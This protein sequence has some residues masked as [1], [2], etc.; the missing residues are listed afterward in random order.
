MRK[1]KSLSILLVVCLLIGCLPLGAAADSDS[2]DTSD[3]EPRFVG[4]MSMSIDLSISSSGLATVTYTAD[5]KSGYTAT[6]VLDLRKVTLTGGSSVKSWTL[7]DIS[8]LYSCGKYYF[9][10]SG[11]SYYVD[12]SVDIYDSDGDF[13]ENIPLE[14]RIVSYT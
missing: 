14:S 2:V 6:V 4:L 12:V 10:A 13:V 5:L 1:V 8:G 3:V 11:H 9:V 7:E